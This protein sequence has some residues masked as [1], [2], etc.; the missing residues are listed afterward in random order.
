MLSQGS[1]RGTCVGVES[2]EDR[3]VSRLGRRRAP[4]IAARCVN[5]LSQGSE[6]NDERPCGV[7][8][9]FDNHPLTPQHGKKPDNGLADDRHPVRTAL[10]APGDDQ[11][12]FPR[13]G[14]LPLT[15]PGLGAPGG[16][17]ASR[18]FS[19]IQRARRSEASLVEGAEEIHAR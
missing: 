4:P 14:H 1:Q 6:T 10:P 9:S 19:Q 3:C 15:Q 17:L 12:I 18:T 2:L 5:E 7:L 16:V 13:R 11:D 8:P